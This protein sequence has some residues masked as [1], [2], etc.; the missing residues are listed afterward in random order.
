MI[1]YKLIRHTGVNGMEEEELDK[2]GFHNWDLVSHNTHIRKDKT[3]VHKYI[4]KK[5]KDEEMAPVSVV[6][7][8][9]HKEPAP[10]EVKKL[11]FFQRLFDFTK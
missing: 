3:L 6:V 7:E 2:L 5:I 1:D 11:N 9:K 4:F 10:V 8:C